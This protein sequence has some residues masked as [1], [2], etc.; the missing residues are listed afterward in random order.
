MQR[1]IHIVKF[2][3]VFVQASLDDT[4]DML[5]SLY[6]DNLDITSVLRIEKCILGREVKQVQ[7]RSLDIVSHVRRAKGG[8]SQRETVCRFSLLS[9]SRS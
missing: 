8:I 1:V 4:T 3:W 6:K 7:S 2:L 5:N 9:L